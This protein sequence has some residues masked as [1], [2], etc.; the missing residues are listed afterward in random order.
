LLLKNGETNMN[1]NNVNKPN[2]REWSLF[3]GNSK[4]KL[5]RAKFLE[6]HG[7]EFKQT[8][9]GWVWESGVKKLI[10]FTT[11][12]KKRTI[13]IFTDK[14]GIKYITDN[15]EGF[16]RDRK[17]N[18]SAMYDVISKKRKSFKGFTVERIQPEDKS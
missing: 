8:S 17:I 10:Q 18:S 4:E 5:N 1:L 11:P 12:K 9:K 2:T 13:Y 15:F 16:C 3:N 14:E 7:G 6:K